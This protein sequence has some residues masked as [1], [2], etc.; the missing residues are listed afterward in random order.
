MSELII[1]DPASIEIAK[2]V[3]IIQMASDRAAEI[4]P[5]VIQAGA[6]LALQAGANPNP[7]AGELYIYPIMGKWT[8]YLGIAYYRRIAEERG[9]RVMFTP[10]GGQPRAM[11]KEEREA[12]NIPEKTFASIAEG[13][14]GDRLLE[15]T[16]AGIPWTSAVIMLTRNGIGILS[17]NE[18]R[19]RDGKYMNP[20]NGRSWQ[21]KCDKRA[22][23]DLY[24]KLGVVADVGALERMAAIAVADEPEVEEGT[25]TAEDL[26]KDMF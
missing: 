7:L 12:Y 16:A 22:E 2:A 10:R 1:V 11:N 21:W 19:G 4:P 5:L 13:F 8:P 17:D 3:K 25:Y 23:M 6:I 20:P 14:R 15:L 18:T 26:N 9:A 24:R